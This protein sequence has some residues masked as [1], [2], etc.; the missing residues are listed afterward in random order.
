MKRT[1]ALAVG[2][3]VIIFCK[4]SDKVREMNALLDDIYEEIRKA[5]G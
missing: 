3:G 1:I 2:I 4:T 5:H